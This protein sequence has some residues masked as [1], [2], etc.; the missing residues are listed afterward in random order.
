MKNTLDLI[1]VLLPTEG[2]TEIGKLELFYTNG[3]L[4][5]YNG[6]SS[7]GIPQHLYLCSDREIKEGWMLRNDN[8]IIA[9]S[10]FIGSEERKA[11]KK[12][13]FTTDHK[14]L[15]EGVPVINGNTKAYYPFREGLGSFE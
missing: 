11:S 4:Q 3:I 14:L 9:V 1:P 8:A 6:G 2:K 15:A 5:I 12:I 7:I 13:E 10:V